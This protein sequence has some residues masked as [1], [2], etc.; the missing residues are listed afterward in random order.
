[1]FAN[2]HKVQKIHK[3]MA[4]IAAQKYSSKVLCRQKG[5]FFRIFNGIP[6]MA[7]ATGPGVI[8]GKALSYNIKGVYSGT[9]N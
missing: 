2:I 6:K 4:E 7:I 8:P 5:I 9:T 1:M 3:A